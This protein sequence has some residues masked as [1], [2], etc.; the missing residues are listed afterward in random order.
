MEEAKNNE[1]RKM[2]TKF[3]LDWSGSVYEHE[4]LSASVFGDAI[5]SFCKE[6]DDYI[7]M[8]STPP[9]N[10]SSYLQAHSPTESTNGLLQV[11]IRFDYPDGSFKHFCYETDDK[12][13]VYWIFA[14][15]WA[16]EELPDMTKFKDITDELYPQK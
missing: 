4:G 8:T 1:G 14:N 9:I 2:G 13:E 16:K 3:S 5:G 7:I 11:E 15:Y 12:K 10:H 6:Y